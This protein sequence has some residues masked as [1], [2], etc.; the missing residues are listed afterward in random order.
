[1]TSAVQP[2]TT[3][4]LCVAV[5]ERYLKALTLLYITLTEVRSTGLLKGKADEHKK[6]LRSWKVGELTQ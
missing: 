3:G 4:E 5:S 6:S 1:M 2:R